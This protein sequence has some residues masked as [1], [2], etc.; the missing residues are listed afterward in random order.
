MTTLA[1]IEA[2]WCRPGRGTRGFAD[3]AHYA[4]SDIVWL[5]E[6]VAR[7]S[8]QRDAAED[9]ASTLRDENGTLREQVA[10]LHDRD[11]ERIMDLEHAR[12]ET[13][14]ETIAAVVAYLRASANAEHPVER[15]VP[16]LSPAG[17]GLLL[18]HADRIERGARL[19]E[20]EPFPG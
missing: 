5:V 19:R 8:A 6:C 17:R 3:V 9:Q 11:A 12:E 10:D 13:R 18:L 15:G 2:R 4:H 16:S 1:D 14:A 20:G 7:V